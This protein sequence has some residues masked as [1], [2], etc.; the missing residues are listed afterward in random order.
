M[1]WEEIKVEP[2]KYY[3]AAHCPNQECSAI[4]LFRQAPCPP[5]PGGP[6]HHTKT[7][8]PALRTN[9]R[10]RSHSS[11]TDSGKTKVKAMSIPQI[12]PPTLQPAGTSKDCGRIARSAR[13]AA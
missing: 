4:F 1:P 5:G 8:V 3:L 13:I 10:L 9:A 12:T 6:S 11:F 7:E 2:G